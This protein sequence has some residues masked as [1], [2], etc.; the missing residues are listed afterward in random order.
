M[1][2]PAL[3]QGVAED[4]L[5]SVPDPEMRHGRKSARKRF[6]DHKAAVAVDTDEQLITAAAVLPGN[7]Q[8]HEQALALVEQSE[9]ATGCAVA[10]T[11]ADGA[12][13]A[14][15]MTVFRAT[16]RTGTCGDRE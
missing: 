11:L 13:G 3:T 6:D 9:A 7:A 14:D 16:H 10:E 15:F 8:D 12:Y 1:D 2:G 4:R 5:V